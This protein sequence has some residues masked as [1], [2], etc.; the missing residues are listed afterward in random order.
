MRF[1]IL[2]S[3]FLCCFNFAQSHPIPDIPV[4]GDF[5]ENGSSIITVEV[6]TRS[7]ADDPEQVPMLESA[8][9]EKLTQLEKDDFLG[10]AEA[11]IANALLVRFDEE[12]WKLPNFK[13]DFVKKLGGNPVEGSD[14][15]IIRG[16]AKRTLSPKI[17]SYQIRARSEA[18]YDLVFTNRLN[19][20]PQ[21]RV[22]VLFPGE[23]SFVLNLKN[24]VKSKE[25]PLSKNTLDNNINQSAQDIRST[26]FS[27][28][29]QGFVH[30]VPLG[31]DH[32][33]F[34]LGLFLLSRKWKPLIL[35][36]TAFTLA[37]TITLGLATIGLISVS[38]QIVEPIIA[39]SIAVVALENIF[40]PGY[41]PYR[42]AVVFIFGLI[43]GLGFAGALSG[44]NLEAT[45]LLLGLF[46]FN[47]GVE[48][49]QVVILITAYVLTMKIM[50]PAD[51]RKWIVIPG[52][53]II[54]LL[55]LY[56]TVERIF[57]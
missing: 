55:G 4:I 21:K 34:V 52:S 28:L 40:F 33:L 17:K 16:Y 31:L 24:F 6:E 53:S 51:Y 50:D 29:R 56:W 18:A 3:I 12:E 38:P 39:A 15:F 19:G 26:F 7:F 14:T 2:I 41:K 25:M 13:Y 47:V 10:K 36:V 1:L 54:A 5:D 42:L 49:G 30:V 45:S 43:H 23:D 35:Q 9:Y 22:N 32:I 44:L 48:F 46:G 20:I 11:Q 8:D 37:H 27:F 57:Y